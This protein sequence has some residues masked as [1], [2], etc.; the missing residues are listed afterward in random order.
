MSVNV[1]L[2]IKSNPEDIDKLKSTFEQILPDT[3]SYD[4]CIGVQVVVNQDDSLNVILIETWE[5]REHYE[6]YL[7][8]RIETGAIDALG[9]MLS[10][11]PSIRYFDNLNI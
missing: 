2:E 5:T 6:K 1:L 7:A 8:W 9:A 4:G 11:A 10:Q 3:R